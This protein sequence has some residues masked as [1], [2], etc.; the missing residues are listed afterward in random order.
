MI[1]RIRTTNFFML[2]LLLGL[3]QLTGGSAS[4]GLVFKD[5]FERTFADCPECPVMV[6]IP[7]GSFTQGSPLGEPQ[8]DEAERPQRQVS[9]ST[10]AMG[11]TEV[12]FNQWMACFADGGCTHNPDDNN[13][14]RGDHP[15]ID[16]SWIDAQQYVNWL[17]D[18]T[19]R[20]YR[21]PSESE[22]EYATRA[23]TTGRFNT[24]DC[25]TT[26]QA[27]FDGRGPALGCEEGVFRAQT[28]PVA[29]FAPNAFGLHDSH[30]NVWEW[31]EDCWNDNYLNA[32]TDGSA[33]RSGDCTR[34]VI[35]GGSW[36]FNGGFQR[37]AVRPLGPPT[38]RR[39]R[40]IGFRVARSVGP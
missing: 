31:V 18:K 34:A 9:I 20:D 23:G 3:L 11:R 29:S 25:I 15:V 36:D 26:D 33:W 7:A 12:T 37:S 6:T 19:G 38:D 16:V 35:R 17:S 27:N 8:S 22:W 5:R 24:G 4:A 39:V 28:L 21:L 40:M 32:P 1:P 30:G 10:F 13:F 14:G 2:P